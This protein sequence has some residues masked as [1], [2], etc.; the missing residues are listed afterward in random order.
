MDHDERLETLLEPE[1]HLQSLLRS[2]GHRFYV[3]ASSIIKHTSNS[4]IGVSY[5]VVL[6]RGMLFGVDRSRR[7]SLPRRLGYVIASPLFPF[8]HAYKLR[9]YFGRF[10]RSYGIWPLVPHYVPQLVTVVIGECIGYLFGERPGIRQW[11][12]QHEYDITLRVNSSELRRMDRMVQQLAA[13]FEAP[14]PSS[15]CAQHV[16]FGGA[17]PV[18]N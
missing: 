4:C 17:H 11:Y 18:A 5:Y 10:V 1:M 9:R 3:E 2:E 7:W 8:I 16:A 6:G 12:A 14:R 13:E 15:D